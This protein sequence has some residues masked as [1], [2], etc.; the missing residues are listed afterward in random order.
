MGKINE[1]YCVLVFFI[2]VKNIYAK[3]LSSNWWFFYR[4]FVS[5]WKWRERC[6]QPNLQSSNYLFSKVQS[7][8]IKSMT[9]TTSNVV[10]TWAYLSISVQELYPAEEPVTLNVLLQFFLMSRNCLS[11]AGSKYFLRF[12]NASSLKS[13]LTAETEFV[14]RLAIMVWFWKHLLTWSRLI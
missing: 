12:W 13:L 8:V 10:S 14:S 11:S 2:I 9:K 1:N 5:V 4:I 3:R 6:L 7:T